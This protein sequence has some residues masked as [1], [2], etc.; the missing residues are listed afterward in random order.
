MHDGGGT[1]TQT[2][3]ALPL[4]ITKLR[5]RGYHLVTIPRLLLDDPPPPG[6]PLPPNLSGD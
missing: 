6:Q 5:A 3:E 1:R 4:I 2:I